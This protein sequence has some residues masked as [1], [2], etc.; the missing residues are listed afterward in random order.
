MSQGLAGRGIGAVAT[1]AGAFGWLALASSAV[2]NP[3]TLEWLLRDR[4]IAMKQV[5]F[6]FSCWSFSLGLSLVVVSLVTR[7][8]NAKHQLICARLSIL[9]VSIAGI[10]LVDR[11]LLVSIGR[12]MWIADRENHYSHRPNAERRWSEK[13]GSKPI[14]LNRF[15]HHDDDFEAHKPAGEFRG[16]VLGDSIV[17]GHG[18]T[19]D[20]AFPNRIEDRL[21]TMLTRDR[22]VQIVNTGVQGYSTF[23]LL[24]T[25]R[26]SLVFDPDIVVVG[27]YLNDVSEPFVVNRRFGGVG[28]DYHGVLQTRAWFLSWLANESGFGRMVQ[29]FQRPEKRRQLRENWSKYAG[30]VVARADRDD[31]RISEGWDL[32][33]NSLTSIFD[34]AEEHGIPVV[35]VVFP[36]TAQLAWPEAQQPQRIV[37]ALA[38]RRKVPVVDLTPVFEDLIFD[39]VATEI[40][41]QRGF[42]V[43]E[44]QDLHSQRTRK[45]FLD[46]DHYTPEGHEIVAERLV[47]VIVQSCPGRFLERDSS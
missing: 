46:S 36:D 30:Q 11:L 15:G 4:A 32:V 3:V 23:Q 34:L 43:D 44:I 40:L 14:R 38:A 12:P 47:P 28:L 18:V 41:L 26:R 5:A 10:V 35:L 1:L 9:L 19:R 27:F 6:S 8:L 22:S 7:R 33:L 25:L 45:Y 20:E 21:E 13:L 39:P 17:M 37:G 24:N 31:P 2:V 16:L 42:A 29:Q